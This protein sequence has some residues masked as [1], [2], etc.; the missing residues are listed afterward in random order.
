MS[1]HDTVRLTI[2]LLGFAFGGIATAQLS[3]AEIGS[4]LTGGVQQFERGELAEARKTFEYILEQE[5]DH[6]IALY[7]LA[8]TYVRLGDPERGLAILDEALAGDIDATAEFYALSASV[9]D[10][11]GRPQDA[12]KRFEQGIT[13]FPDNHNLHLN[14]GVTQMRLGDSTAARATFERTVT[15]QPQHPSAHF[16]LGQIYAMEGRGA[17][18][19]LALGTSVSLDNQ[20]QRMAA[21]T[22]MIK[23]IMD[24]QIQILDDGVPMAVIPV[25]SALPATTLDQI[26]NRLP[27]HVAAGV[28]MQRKSE[29]DMSY[30][31]Y[32]IAYGLLATAFVQSDID[33]DSDFASGHYFEFYEPIA[34]NGHS[35]T[36][37]HLILASLN[38][39][40]A[41]AWV[42][43]NR[44]RVE[45]FTVWV[46]SR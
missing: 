21:A 32:A 3:D 18:A 1:Y 36:F 29:G 10:N 24:S 33:P 37:G 20:R 39:N 26:S 2:A 17:A 23:S 13:E 35:N 31:P 7:E 42:Q 5:P 6:A 12:L 41:S 27:M 30:E 38:P 14:L 22:G 46:Q 40:A 44:E 15:L 9:L 28:S 16:F 34:E 43:G 45:D 25:D 11:L 8:Y 19:I 4:L